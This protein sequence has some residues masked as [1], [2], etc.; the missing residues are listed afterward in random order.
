MKR[1][2][3]LKCVGIDA[4]R[5]KVLKQRDQLP[6]SDDPE[7]HEAVSAR[8]SFTLDEAFRLRLMLDLVGG[9]NDNL[10]GLN[11][12]YAT[13][14]VFNAIGRFDVH[15]LTR[16]RGEDLWCGVIAFE[17]H[18][19]DGTTLR[20]SGWFAADLPSLPAFIA[21]NSK[22]ARAV[23]VFIAN[24]SLAADRVRYAAAA[25]SAADDEGSN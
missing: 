11:P 25:L 12:S 10:Q 7:E 6:F 21:A 20:Y 18:N 1:S 23:R 9:E 24:A 3:F 2:D 19:A 17:D 14:M 13:K 15:P 16:A 22:G 4:G 8:R 5:F